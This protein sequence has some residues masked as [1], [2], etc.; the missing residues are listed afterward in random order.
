MT[1]INPLVPGRELNGSGVPEILYFEPT[2]ANTR[3][4]MEGNYSGFYAVS[5]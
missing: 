4:V 5:H 3:K 2:T 1:Q